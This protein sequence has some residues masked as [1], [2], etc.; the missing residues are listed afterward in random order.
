MTCASRARG[1]LPH[2]DSSLPSFLVL[3]RSVNCNTNLNKYETTMDV[4]SKANDQI[5]LNREE[6]D[7]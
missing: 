3:S 4:N 5:D 6:V 7:G 2:N 1:S